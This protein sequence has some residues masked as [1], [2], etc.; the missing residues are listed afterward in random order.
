MRLLTHTSWP[1]PSSSFIVYQSYLS[2]ASFSSPPRFS[3]FTQASIF[4]VI[5]NCVCLAPPYQTWEAMRD[6]GVLSWPV[7]RNLIS[8]CVSQSFLFQDAWESFTSEKIFLCINC[9]E[10]CTTL[11]VLRMKI[12]FICLHIIML[13]HKKILEHYVFL[14]RIYPFQIVL[15]YTYTHTYTHTCEHACTDMHIHRHIHTCVLRL[16]ESVLFLHHAVPELRLTTSSL[17]TSAFI[18]SCLSGLPFWIFL[19]WDI[20]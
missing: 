16:E 5:L 13:K 15:F 19:L 3:S 20:R 11:P 7:D 2:L 6:L 14:K 4:Q 9:S 1:C 12:P 8:N 18:Q 17:W 10:I